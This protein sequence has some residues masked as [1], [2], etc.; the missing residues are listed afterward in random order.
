MLLWDLMIFDSCKTR[1]VEESN[2]L[3]ITSLHLGVKMNSVKSY[4]GSLIFRKIEP[5]NENLT[6]YAARLSGHLGS[7]ERYVLLYVPTDIAIASYGS[8]VGLRWMQ[9]SMAFTNTPSKKYIIQKQS[10]RYDPFQIVGTVYYDSDVDRH[11]SADRSIAILINCFEKPNS[12]PML[13]MLEEYSYSIVP[14]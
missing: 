6:I 11:I 3:K 13:T 12:I 9:L 5:L 14:I 8:I 10:V 2:A 4:F 7:S 1:S